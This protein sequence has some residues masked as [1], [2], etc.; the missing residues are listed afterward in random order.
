[1]Y[2]FSN[3]IL[4][5]SSHKSLECRWC[6]AVTHFYH[7][8][9]ECSKYCG[10]R[11][12]MHVFRLNASLLISLSHVQLRPESSPHYVMMNSVLLGEGC[13]VLPCIIVLLAQICWV[14][15]D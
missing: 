14:V 9:L 13:Y 10:E 11:G 1:M 12:F 6:I 5:Y 4:E 15:T 7:T 8:A 2:E 3:K